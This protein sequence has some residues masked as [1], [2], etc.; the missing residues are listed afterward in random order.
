M[1]HKINF[2]FIDIIINFAIAKLETIALF[3]NKL[4]F[5][6]YITKRLVILTTNLL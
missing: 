2:H 6:V 5:G 3:C 1:T 4:R